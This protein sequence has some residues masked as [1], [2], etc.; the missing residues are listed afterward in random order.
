MSQGQSSFTSV[1]LPPRQCRAI[2]LALRVAIGVR[3]A[4]AA[5]Q[6]DLMR[7]MRF[8]PGDEKPLIERDAALGLGVELDHPAFDPFRIELIVDRPIERVGEID[9][10]PIAADL[11]HL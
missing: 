2:A 4:I 10:A 6:P 8:W 1:P 11:D 7:T 5:L 3:R 9:P